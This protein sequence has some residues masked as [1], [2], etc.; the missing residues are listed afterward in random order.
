MTNLSK[1]QEEA[2]SIQKLKEFINL[3]D[4][5]DDLKISTITLT[6]SFNALFNTENIGKYLGLSADRII[7]IKYGDI[8]GEAPKSVRT[9]VAPTK[10][11]KQGKSRKVKCTKAFYNQVTIVIKTKFT[12]STVNVKLFQNGSLQMTG[13]KN[14]YS[15]TEALNILCSELRVVKAIFDPITKNKIIPKPFATNLQNVSLEKINDFKIRLINSNFKTGFKID[16]DELYKLLLKKDIYCTFE[17]DVHAAINIKHNYKNTEK[18][19]IFVF[20]S[21]AII[22]TG[23]KHKDQLVDAYKFINNVLYEN[24]NKIVLNNLD[25]IIN[26]K[27]FQD[28]LKICNNNQNKKKGK[29]NRYSRLTTLESCFNQNNDYENAGVIEVFI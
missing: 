6:C 27:E 23:A 18:I 11:K 7:S 15:C 1:E 19:S 26:R 5:P 3:E 17:P 28:L 2:V 25:N 12:D 21:G 16:R 9:N 8:R 29:G 20:E 22:I 13:C 24:Y 14:F 10:T 4:L